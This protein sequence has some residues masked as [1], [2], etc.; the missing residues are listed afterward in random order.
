[1]LI[2]PN[3][4]HKKVFTEV[5]IIGLERRKRLKDLLVRENIP[6]E[7]QEME[8]LAVVRKSASKV[9]PFFK[10]KIFLLTKSS[11]IRIR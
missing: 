1:M 7:K 6:V 5:P 2:T 3:A 4:Q 9:A 11:V 8:S 10:K